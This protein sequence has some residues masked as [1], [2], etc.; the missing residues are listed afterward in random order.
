MLI[1]TKHGDG[2]GAWQALSDHVYREPDDFVLAELGEQ[3]NHMTYVTCGFANKITA[4]PDFAAKLNIFNKKLPLAHRKM[5]SEIA[6]KVL[7]SFDKQSPIGLLAA[8]KIASKS[9]GF[10][11]VPP[12][13]ERTRD[14][15]EVMR[16]FDMLWRA[17]FVDTQGAG[18]GNQADGAYY[19]DV[20]QFCN[21][22][23]SA[24]AVGFSGGKSG[25]G[26]GRGRRACTTMLWPSTL[27]RSTP[28]PVPHHRGV[29][30]DGHS[31]LLLL[32]RLW[33]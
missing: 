2:V 22:Y 14:L 9:L 33:P 28:R 3:F 20:D 29:P 19:G 21:D 30:Q 13:T 17:Q 6:L 16:H 26:R 7:I 18:S 12:S 32:P 23:D 11:P 4:V 1:N 24:F 31:T 27:G 25:R 15:L 10:A 8:V 5:P